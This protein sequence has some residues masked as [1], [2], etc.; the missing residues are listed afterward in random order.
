MR[1]TANASSKRGVQPGDEHPSPDP[2]AEAVRRA[3]EAKRPKLRYLVG[4]D[5]HLSAALKRALPSTAFR[6]YMRR[7][8]GIGG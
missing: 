7:S 8:T 2:V 5:A 6:S 4:R 3:L 1:A